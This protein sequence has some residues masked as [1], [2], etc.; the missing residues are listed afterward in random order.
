MKDLQYSSLNTQKYLLSTK[1]N[2]RRKK[3]LF[4]LRT[5]MMSTPDNFGIKTLCKICSIEED[6]TRHLLNCIFLKLKV[7]EILANND[8]NLEDAFKN[9]IQN[10]NKLSIVI[11]KA[12]RKREELRKEFELQSKFKF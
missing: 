7:P 4:K 8:V 9:K 2:L 12:W 11:E 10:M 3:L 1:I 6:T 5:R